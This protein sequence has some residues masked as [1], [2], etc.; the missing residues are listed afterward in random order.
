MATDTFIEKKKVTAKDIKVP[1]KYKVVVL[2]DNV[3]PM[4]FVI[5]ML[6]VV[7]KQT[8]EDAVQLTLKIHNDGSAIAGIYTFEIAEQKVLDGTTLARNNGFPLLLKAEA[9]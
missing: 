1:P 4:D 8:E 3:T 5:S 6:M 7:F 9:E 2:N